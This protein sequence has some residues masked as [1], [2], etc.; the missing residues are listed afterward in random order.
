MPSKVVSGVNDIVTTHPDL[1]S[2]WHPIKNQPLQPS[3]T[4]AGTAKKI[5]WRCK[6]DPRHEWQ[7]T[8]DSRVSKRTGCPVCTNQLVITGVNDLAFVYPSI[9]REWMA[10]KNAPALPSNTSA[11]SPKA[12][13][14]QCK[15]DARHLWRAPVYSRT[16][17]GTGCPYCDGK[18]TLGGQNDLATTHPALAAEW[19]PNKNGNLRPSEVVAGTNKKIW[20][21]CKVND[22]HEWSTSGGQRLRGRGC[23]FCSNQ[24]LLKGFNDMATTHPT[25]AH[26]WHPTKNLPLR[27]TDVFAQTGKKLW[28][29]CP[30]DKSHEWQATGGNRVAGTGCP[31]CSNRIPTRGKNDLATA[32][33]ALAAQW[34]YDRNGDLQPSDLVVGSHKRVWWICSSNRNHSWQ[35]TVGHRAKSGCPICGNRKVLQGDNDLLS[36]APELAHQWHTALNGSLLPYQVTIGSSRKVWWVCPNNSKHEWQTTV[37]SR[38]TSGCPFCSNKAILSGFNDLQTTHPTLAKEWDLTRNAPLLP[39]MVSAGS[40]KRAWWQCPHHDNHYWQATISSRRTLKVGCPICANL[41]V[42]RGFNDFATTNPGLALEWHPTKNAPLLPNEIVAGTQRVV[43]WQCLNNPE[44]S[45]RAGVKN[46]MAGTGCPACT[47]YG[48]QSTSAGLLYFIENE[49]LRARKVGITNPQARADRLGRFEESGWRTIR[50]WFD[51]D[52]LVILNLE[53][54][55]LRWIRKDLGL[56]PFLTSNDMGRQGGWSETF[57]EDGIPNKEVIEKV[58]LELLK[59]KEISE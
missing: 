38:K 36:T 40:S 44:H 41:Q 29:Q 35:A 24:V 58:D 3:E 33:P 19:H 30:A 57:S 32:S 1:A 31:F 10:G 16:K 54:A 37:A 47:N 28:W 48:Y 22:T 18:K 13:W 45:W 27:P 17:L 46:R 2:E 11:A 55:V 42:L 20:W 56:P 23:P 14:W 15:V 52:G 43:W 7:A 53:T 9:A 25:L 12:Y 51:E 6:S 8:G 59:L 39:T 21:L 50:T 49:R 5:W 26:Q 34:D 4:R